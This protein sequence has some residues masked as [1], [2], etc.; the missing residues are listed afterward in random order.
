MYSGNAALHQDSRAMLMSPE[1]WS[2]HAIDTLLRGVRIAPWNPLNS[3][4]L[5]CRLEYF[6]SL[7]N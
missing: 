1:P 2:Q 5:S 6:P 4:G 7:S 3:C